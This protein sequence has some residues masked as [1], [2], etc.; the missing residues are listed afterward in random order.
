ML[1]LTKR[2]W[3]S[4]PCAVFKP[5][6]HLKLPI[7][8]VHLK[9]INR[10]CTLLYIAVSEWLTVGRSAPDLSTEPRGKGDSGRGTV[11][12]ELR[13]TSAARSLDRQ[14][15]HGHSGEKTARQRDKGDAGVRQCTSR[16]HRTIYSHARTGNWPQL[17]YVTSVTSHHARTM[18]LAWRQA[19]LLP[20]R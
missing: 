14:E 12:R 2:L 1:T 16:A 10:L 8:G 6:Y 7:T 3:T 13:E 15:R 17:T 11:T 19:L 9:R 20:R 18:R 5:R 4:Y